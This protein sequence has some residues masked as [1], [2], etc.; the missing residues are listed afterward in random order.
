MSE[1]RALSVHLQLHFKLSSGC[2]V[3]LD[4][5]YTLNKKHHQRKT[6]AIRLH[7]GNNLNSMCLNKT[8][9]ILSRCFLHIYVHTMIF[10]RYIY[11]I[12]IH[13]YTVC[14][15]TYIYTHNCTLF[16]SSSLASSESTRGRLWSSR[17]RSCARCRRRYFR[18]DATWIPTGFS[19]HR[20]ILGVPWGETHGGGYQTLVKPH[21]KSRILFDI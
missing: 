20:G 6:P 13:L 16:T 11:I 5:I 9:T 10:Q 1:S 8:S 2:L 4:V 3:Q 14:E 19:K 15:Y 18:G 12:Y 17:R 21:G 7:Y